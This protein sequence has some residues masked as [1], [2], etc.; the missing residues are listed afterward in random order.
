MQVGKAGADV[1]FQDPAKKSTS[2]G[3]TVYPVTISTL[4]EFGNLAAVGRR[5]LDAG[6]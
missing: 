2:V 1:L 5:L 3:I 4:E 6:E